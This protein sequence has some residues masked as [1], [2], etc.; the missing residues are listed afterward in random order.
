MTLTARVGQA[1]GLASRADAQNDAALLSE[2]RD[3][4]SRLVP[5]DMLATLAASNPR[6]ARSELQRAC[7]QVFEGPQW[8]LRSGH[9]QQRLMR[10]LEDSV[11]GLGP[12]QDLIDDPSVTEVMVNGTSSVY[13]EREGILHEVSVSFS[14]DAQVRALIDRILAPLGR[15]VDESS[16]MVDARLEGGHRVNV[17]IPPIAV[18]GPHVTIRKFTDRAMTLAE[19]QGL[20]SFDGD[21]AAFFRFTVGARKNVAVCGGTGSG[22]TTLL[23]A[24][25]CEISHDERIVTIEDSV[26][27]RFTE[28]PHVVRLEARSMNAEGAGEV[29]IRDLVR[30]SLRMRPNRIIVGECRGAEA[31]DMLQAMNTG[32][33]GSLT[34]LHANSPHD[35]VSR[36]VTMVRYGS[37]LPVE[38]IQ[39]NIASALD[40]IVQTERGRDGQRFVSQIAGVRRGDASVC[41]VTP[42]YVRASRVEAGQWRALPVWAEEFAAEFGVLRG[43]RADQGAAQAPAAKPTPRRWAA[44]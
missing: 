41:E 23:N 15:R 17:V 20:G 19:M 35:A 14:S 6:R 7:R 39:E 42:Y 9:T 21:V 5:G 40:V 4:V 13:V 37:E 10:E 36:L 26:E 12:L 3:Q 29:T 25:S 44:A 1:Q 24:L 27:L 8:S 31:L 11:F 2:L 16:P 30:N 43:E 22:K 32:H 33:D 28:H 18:D 38:V 34:T